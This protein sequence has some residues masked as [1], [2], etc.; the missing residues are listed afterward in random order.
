M[1][2]K[3]D[4]ELAGISECHTVK[5]SKNFLPFHLGRIPFRPKFLYPLSPD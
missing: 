2:E 4:K 5:L 3:I 1:I